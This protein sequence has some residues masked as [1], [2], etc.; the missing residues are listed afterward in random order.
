MYNI[1]YFKFQTDV[2]YTKGMLNL[3]AEEY[4][5]TTQK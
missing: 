4:R 1:Q 2:S 5:F 3:N